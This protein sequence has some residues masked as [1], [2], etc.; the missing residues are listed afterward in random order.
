MPTTN[1]STVR[2]AVRDALATDL[3]TVES[4]GNTD[5][6]PS[7]RVLSGGSVRP[8]SVAAGD[9]TLFNIILQIWVLRTEVEGEWTA[10]D[11]EDALDAVEQEI[12]AW[13][14]ANVQNPGVWKWL[15]YANQSDVREVADKGELWLVESISLQVR[16]TDP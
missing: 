8:P 5:D 13:V 2:K 10:D 1:R 16:A 12:G 9:D 15:R 6:S 4:F 11:A 14:D 7:L 3:T